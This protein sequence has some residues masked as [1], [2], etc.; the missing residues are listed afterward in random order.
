[1]SANR[2]DDAVAKKSSSNAVKK[3]DEQI[4]KLTELDDRIE[5]KE[6]TTVIDKK[7]LEKELKENG[8]K[9]SSTTKKTTTSKTN[10]TNKTNKTN[11]TKN[12]SKNSGS[13]IGSKGETTKKS[14]TISSKGKTSNTKPKSNI[15]KATETTVKIKKL[16]N[17]IRDLYDMEDDLGK[18]R[19][20][21]KIS[22]VIS[23]KAVKVEKE[24]NNKIENVSDSFLNKL[25]LIVFAIF[26]VFF[27][28]FVG[29]IIFISTF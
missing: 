12:N 27:I 21:S 18:T 20:F 1:M 11:K 5:K 25:L 9:K 13:K 28:I 16:E 2:G 4:K 26:M 7:R 17:E 24:L 15:K 29:F 6:V 19:E 14:T 10:N 23:S 22:D 8:P 3:L